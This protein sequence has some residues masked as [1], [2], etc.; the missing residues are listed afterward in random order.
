MIVCFG[1]LKARVLVVVA[2]EAQQFPVA[3]VGWIVVVIVILVMNGEFSQPVSAEFT[4]AVAANVGK[5][6]ERPLSV[7]LFALPLISAGLCNDIGCPGCCR[8][9]F[10]SM[11]ALP[12]CGFS[13]RIGI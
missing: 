3:A 6:F 1:N 10:S 12:W 5:Q 13:T 4:S 11:S 9:R 8:N 7:A 2:I